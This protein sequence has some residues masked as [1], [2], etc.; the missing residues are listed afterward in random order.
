MTT[1]LEFEKPVAELKTRIAD[2]RDSADDGSID[3]AAEVERVE[4]K[5]E[6]QL[7]D[8][9]ARLTPWQ[10]TQVARHPERPHF[11][12]Y[13]AALIADFTPLAGDR[14]F[15]EDAA[16][17]GGLGRFRGRPVVVMG[18]EKGNDTTSRLRHNFGMAKPEGYRKAI[19]LMKL[20]DQFRLPV[21]TFV[22]TAGAFPGVEAEERGQAEAIARSTEAC[23]SLGVPMIAAVVG[24]GGSGGAIALAA[25]NRVLMFE[26]AIYSV[27][28][29]EGCASILWRSADKAADAAEAMRIT[30]ADLKRLN[31]ID[32]IVAEPLGGAHRDPAAAIATLG[33]AMEEEL[34]AL[35]AMTEAAL[36]A[37]RRR[38]F[39]E[40]SA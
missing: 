12:D 13:A 4:A 30:A 20:A 28:S 25:A 33:D 6:R 23:L 18:H 15:G 10:R 31:V 5:A 17:T 39:L 24:E 8:L 40:M 11:K 2:L 9:Y 14:N 36:L 37:D 38:K 29:P 22:D 27:I 34:S 35:S 21:I 16:I 7:R 3:I 32:R 19:R 26:N 1:F